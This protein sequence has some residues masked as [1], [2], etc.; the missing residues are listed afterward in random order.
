MIVEKRSAK[1]KYFEITGIYVNIMLQLNLIYKPVKAKPANKLSEIS[2]D[3]FLSQL[4]TQWRHQETNKI[5]LS[6][7]FES[8]RDVT[9]VAIWFVIVFRLS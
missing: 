6:S 5:I 7:P 9:L 4:K 1:K 3:V 2:C 8:T